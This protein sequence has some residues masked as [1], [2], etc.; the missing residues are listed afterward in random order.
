MKH[1]LVGAPIVAVI[2]SVSLAAF[3]AAWW[4]VASAF[5][6]VAPLMIGMT[7]ILCSTILP[8]H[9]DDDGRD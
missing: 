3:G 4:V 8:C 9:R 2:S 5:F 7:A 6:G 1:V